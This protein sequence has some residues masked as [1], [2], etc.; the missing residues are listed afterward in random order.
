MWLASQQTVMGMSLYHYKIG[1]PCLTG[2]A[3]AI[4][5]ERLDTAL[6]D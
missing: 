6:T 4:Y 5:Q 3:E 1:H 2:L